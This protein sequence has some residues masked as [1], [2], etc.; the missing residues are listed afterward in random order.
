MHTFVTFRLTELG[1]YIAVIDEWGLCA[2]FCM[3]WDTYN[4]MTP[5][6][7]K[8][9]DEIGKWAAV[10]YDRLTHK[11]EADALAT[12]REMGIEVIRLTP[13]E[14]ER[15][16]EVTAHLVDEWAAKTDEQGLPGTELINAMLKFRSDKGW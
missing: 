12:C 2:A 11:E 3:N 15:W 4:K 5:A 16:K 8:A 10:E 7:Q 1:K 14:L 6:D 9:I 13:E